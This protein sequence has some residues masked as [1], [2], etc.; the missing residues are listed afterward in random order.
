VGRAFRAFREQTLADNLIA[1]GMN[2]IVAA[3]F[4]NVLRTDWL[5][6]TDKENYA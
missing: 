6:F 5:K 4:W 1:I 2:G 3:Y